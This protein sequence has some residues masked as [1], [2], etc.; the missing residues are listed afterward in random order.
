[1]N[2]ASY[3]ATFLMEGIPI[4]ASRA[5]AAPEEIPYNRQ[6]HQILE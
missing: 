1:M 6:T 3:N 2:G 5:R 4:A